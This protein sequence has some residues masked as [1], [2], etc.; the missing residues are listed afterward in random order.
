MNIGLKLAVTFCLG[1]AG[2]GLGTLS[3]SALPMNGRV[4][5]TDAA[6][7]AAKVETVRWVCNY[8]GNCNWVP[9]RRWG[10]G[11]RPYYGYYRPWRQHHRYYGWGGGPWRHYW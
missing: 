11:P 6:D 9:G 2:L 3:A 8:W 10:Y 1:L 5:S 7:T 4:A